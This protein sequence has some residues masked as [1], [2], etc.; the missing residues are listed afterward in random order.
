MENKNEFTCFDPVYYQAK[1]T[2]VS[3]E[4]YGLK[5][6]DQDAKRYIRLC[7]SDELFGMFYPND[8]A[9]KKQFNQSRRQTSY[10]RKTI[11]PLPKPISGLNYKHM[12]GKLLGSISAAP[13]MPKK[14]ISPWTQNMDVDDPWGKDYNDHFGKDD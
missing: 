8:K 12:V 4:R 3:P 14:I 2:D 6:S 13:Q 1:P 9:N 7:C 11:H 10:N 5:L